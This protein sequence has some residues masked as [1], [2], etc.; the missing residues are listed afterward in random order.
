MRLLSKKL[1]IIIPLMFLI[2][3]G[4]VT[5]GKTLEEITENMKEATIDF[6]SG[7]ITRGRAANSPDQPPIA[8]ISKRN[9]SPA[10]CPATFFIVLSAIAISARVR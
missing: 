6:P 10:S 2:L 1:K 9:R 8:S 4:C 3:P 7:W 5:T